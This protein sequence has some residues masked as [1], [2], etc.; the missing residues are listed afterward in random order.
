MILLLPVD[1]NEDLGLIVWVVMALVKRVNVDTRTR[2]EHIQHRAGFQTRPKFLIWSKTRSFDLFKVK[3]LGHY[4]TD[5]FKFGNFD[6][7]LFWK[8]GIY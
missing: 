3:L 8:P 6:F 2:F 7:I 1:M 4:T 5:L